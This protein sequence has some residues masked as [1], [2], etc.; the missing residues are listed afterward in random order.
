MHKGSIETHTNAILL[1]TDL[2]LLLYLFTVCL[3]CGEKMG[4]VFASFKGNN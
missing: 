4:I 1:N 2:S 3:K